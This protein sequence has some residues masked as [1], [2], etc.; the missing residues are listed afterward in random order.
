MPHR[1]PSHWCLTHPI[2]SDVEA[3]PDGHPT[4]GGFLPLVP[5]PRRMWR[6]ARSHFIEPLRVGDLAEP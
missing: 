5:L 2:V 3:R 6:A 1:S 4:S